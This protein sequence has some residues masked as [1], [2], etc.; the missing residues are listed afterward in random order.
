MILEKRVAVDTFLGKYLMA[1]TTVV[2]IKACART[3]KL[4]LLPRSE[5][6][7]SLIKI[8]T[9]VD[10]NK[11]KNFE[12]IAFSFQRGTDVMRINKMIM[13]WDGGTSHCFNSVIISDVVSMS[14]I[15]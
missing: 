3:S 10:V 6:S 12:M 2:A 7:L 9:R 14:K 13:L 1:V 5:I 11:Y 8:P 15:A 4:L